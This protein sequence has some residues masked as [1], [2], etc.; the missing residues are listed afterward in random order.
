MITHLF[1]SKCQKFLSIFSSLK[2][3]TSLEVTTALNSAQLS[4]PI[5]NLI[6]PGCILY[7]IT[8]LQNIWAVG[9]GGMFGNMLNYV[10]IW[11]WKLC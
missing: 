10:T 4:K 11:N 9:Y 7:M 2:D 3:F 6:P 5:C 1:S 8:E